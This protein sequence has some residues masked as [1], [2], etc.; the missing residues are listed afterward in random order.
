LPEPEI[1]QFAANVLKAQPEYIFLNVSTRSAHKT[2]STGE[3]VHLTVRPTAWWR[4]TFQ[5]RWRGS[6]SCRVLRDEND[7]C[8][9]L[10]EGVKTANSESVTNGGK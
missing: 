5:Q 10:F 2:F 7:E 9:L 8:T 1:F 4:D 6:Y 3:N